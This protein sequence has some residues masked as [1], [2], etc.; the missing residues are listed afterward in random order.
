MAKAIFDMNWSGVSTLLKGKEMQDI[1]SR[2][3]DQVV[4]QAG[5]GYEKT[6][7]VGSRRCYATITPTSI[8]ASKKNLKHN[9][10]VKALGAAKL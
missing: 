1:C 9:T 4:A 10:L 3:G 6:V 8:E 2:L 5:E 7:H